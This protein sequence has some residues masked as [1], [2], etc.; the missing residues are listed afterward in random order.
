MMFCQVVKYS[1]DLGSCWIVP[2]HIID[3]IGI[4]N[5]NM[6]SQLFLGA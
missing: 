4:E 6:I 2:K 1:I 5:E 3:I